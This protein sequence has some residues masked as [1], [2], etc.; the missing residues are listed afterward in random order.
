MKLSGTITAADFTHEDHFLFTVKVDKD[1]FPKTHITMGEL[2][3]VN[4]LA[5]PNRG[6]TYCGKDDH[7]RPDCPLI[8]EEMRQLR[9][10]P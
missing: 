9:V 5:I 10:R 8:A 4:T 2:V 7:W 1:L 6:C 3:A